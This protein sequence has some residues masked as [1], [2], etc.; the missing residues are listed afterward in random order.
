MFVFEWP[1]PSDTTL[2]STPASRRRLA[3]VCLPSCSLIL[4]SAFGR[5]G[6]LPEPA[7]HVVRPVRGAV[8]PAEDQ[9]VVGV[10]RAPGEF[11]LGPLA[12]LTL[13]QVGRACVEHDRALAGPGLRAA[14]DDLP[15]ELEQRTGHHQVTLA[16][17]EPGSARAP[18]ASPRRSPCS[19]T[20]RNSTDSRSWT[21]LARSPGTLPTCSGDQ[22]RAGSR[23]SV[24][25]SSEVARVVVDPP[26]LP[27]GVERGPQGRE[28]PSLGRD[29]D[30]PGPLPDVQVEDRRAALLLGEEDLLV[31][32]G[33]EVEHVGDVFAGQPVER[34]MPEQR[35]EEVVD[36]PAVQPGR[37]L[38]E[39]PLPGQPL[40][41]VLPQ[42]L[43]A[44]E[45]AAQA[46]PPA[47]VVQCRE[48]AAAPGLLEDQVTD[49]RRRLGVALGEGVHLVDPA[50][51]VLRG[52]LRAEAAPPESRS[53]PVA[54]SR[55]R[56]SNMPCFGL[57]AISGH[58]VPICLPASSRQT[59]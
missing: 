50:A 48:L 20:S 53:P 30:H 13:H 11:L 43:A 22:V 16:M 5:H 27:R 28:D 38:A 7:G 42:G 33:D 55:S 6:Q 41:Q 19:S 36:V 2:M 45:V 10:R 25:I 52:L 56:Y 59:Q 14:L 26:R 8:F 29:V 58:R 1:S 51:E 47:H 31:P 12:A 23:Y 44:V 4:G 15:A 57:A 32:L 9:V 35:H 17:V 49:P 46:E 40:G 39:L 21:R 54:G 24:G 34:D 37:G 18:T 3:A